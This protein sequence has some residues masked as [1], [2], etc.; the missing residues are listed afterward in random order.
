MIGIVLVT[1]G[2]LALE[3]LATAEYIVGPQKNVSS[4]CFFPEDDMSKKLAELSEKVKEVNTGD[5]VV[6]LTDMFGGTPSN[7]AIS[8]MEKNKVEVLAGLNLP[9]LIKLVR[10]RE[11]MPL[12][13]VVFAAKE[14]GQKY[15]NIASEL[16]APE[17]AEN[18][19]QKD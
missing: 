2:N 11:R 3:M 10:E 18:G 12:N 14:A 16:L 4:V 8:L 5:G 7:L 9:M 17:K 15:I 1:H 13:K 19:V 6:L